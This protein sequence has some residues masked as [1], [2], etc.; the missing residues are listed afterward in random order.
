MGQARSNYPLD[1]KQKVIE[2]TQSCCILL[3]LSLFGFYF[4]ASRETKVT[5]PR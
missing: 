3:R 5:A 2:V 1:E 4:D